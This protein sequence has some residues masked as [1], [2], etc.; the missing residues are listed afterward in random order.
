MN[1]SLAPEF[2]LLQFLKA[3]TLLKSDTIWRRKDPGITFVVADATI[4]LAD[5][6]YCRKSDSILDCTAMAV[7]VVGLKILSS[8]I[9]HCE[10]FVAAI[11]LRE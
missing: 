7:A 4:T 10:Q 6:S 3:S 8:R 11:F 1:H 2:I 9:C 5:R